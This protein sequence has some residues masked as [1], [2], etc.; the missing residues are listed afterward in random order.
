MLRLMK[1]NRLPQCDG[2]CES[3]R[4]CQPI[5]SENISVEVN[6]LLG[7]ATQAIKTVSY[8]KHLECLCTCATQSQVCNT[9]CTFF[10]FREQ[11]VIKNKYVK[12]SF[13]V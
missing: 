4:N 11:C 2:C 8:P 6:V 10:I 13:Q 12:N 3:G 5:K 9:V 7:N 1:I